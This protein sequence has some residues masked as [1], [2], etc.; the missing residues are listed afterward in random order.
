MLVEDELVIYCGH[1][2][3]ERIL[4]RENVEA[5]DFKLGIGNSGKTGSITGTGSGT[6]QVILMGCSSGLLHL[7]GDYEPNGYAQALLLS[8]TTCLA[9]NLW[10]V[11][12]KDIDKFTETL[13]TNWTQHNQIDG[14][15]NRL[16]SL[17]QVV[18]ESRH[19]C[20]MQGLSGCAP[21]CYGMPVKCFFG[22]S[23]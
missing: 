20:K 2:S 3:G 8:G 12:D 14:S 6:H 1:G 11:T 4:S 7:Y 21:V 19:V 23:D 17:P 5:L 22:S 16:K 9:A 18:S 10:D 13:L 15:D